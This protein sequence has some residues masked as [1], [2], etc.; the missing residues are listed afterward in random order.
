MVQDLNIFLNF[1]TGTVVGFDQTEV[2][3]TEGETVT[4][5]TSFKNNIT[6]QTF[7]RIFNSFQVFTQ[8]GA[9]NATG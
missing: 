9:G 2:T 7:Q 3:V 8:Q 1:L 6:I 5:S 4:L